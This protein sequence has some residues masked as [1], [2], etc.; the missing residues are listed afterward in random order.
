MNQQQ[1]CDMARQITKSAPGIVVMVLPG[2]G[3]GAGF[4][5]GQDHASALQ[6]IVMAQHVIEDFKDTVLEAIRK[7]APTYS[8][9]DLE[10]DLTTLD[11]HLRDKPPDGTRVVEWIKRK[12]D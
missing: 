3:V 6:A 11:R 5:T 1:L 7:T 9:A 8:R 12:Q 4:N 2:V 10:H